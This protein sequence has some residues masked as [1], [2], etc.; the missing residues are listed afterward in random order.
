MKPLAIVILGASGNLARKKL[1]PALSILH[2]RKKLPSSYIVAGCGRTEHTNESFRA[3]LGV[4]GEFAESVVYKTG[5][6]G[7]KKFLADEF[8]KRGAG[9]E[10]DTMIFMAL[11]PAVFEKTASE[12]CMEGFGKTARLVVEKP[13]GTDLESAKTL[14]R[15]LLECFPEERIFR[16]DHYLA[17]EAVQNILVFR[18]AN[19]IFDSAWNSSCIES[20]HINALETSGVEDRGAYFDNAG[21]I[22]DM[23]QNHLIQLLCLIT[24]DAPVSLS[25]EDIR[26]QKL[27][28]LRA[29]RIDK[30]VCGQYEKY[31]IERG[32]QPDSTTPTFTEMQLSVNTMRWSGVPI[33]IRAGKSMPR[34]G[35]EIGIRFK[36]LPRV[37]F[38]EN[39]EIEPNKVIFKIQPGE[40]IVI[41]MAS[42]IPGREGGVASANMNFCYRDTFSEQIPEAYQ[43]L[44]L[45]AVN[46]DKTLFV[47][48]EEIELAWKVVDKVGNY[49]SKFSYEGR[50]MPGTRLGIDWIDF[51]RYKGVCEI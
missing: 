47:S 22:R 9:E 43:R 14:N 42:K 26:Q 21:I 31:G 10:Y 7:L 23:V 33:Y 16:I 11:P 39:D 45:D 19:M 36:H 32:V 27:Q 34:T 12:L 13:F 50:V 41:D 46:G 3:V 28:I 15:S 35:T 49:T 8:L 48:S 37:L 29:M 1:L 20:I 25:S 17:K 24:M 44:L 40:G 18:F 5:I 6:A 4:A 30:C 38:N 2:Q 51:E